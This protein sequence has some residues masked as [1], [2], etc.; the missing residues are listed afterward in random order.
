V[1]ALGATACT[2]GGCTYWKP[3]SALIISPFWFTSSSTVNPPPG[4]GGSV[5]VTCFL[6]PLP[7]VWSCLVD[8]S[9]SPTTSSSNT[10][11]GGSPTTV[12]RIPPTVGPRSGHVMNGA[13]GTKKRRS[14]VSA[15]RAVA[16][17]TSTGAGPRA[18]AGETNSSASLE[19]QREPRGPRVPARAT[20]ASSYVSKF[21]PHTASATPPD[22]GLLGGS[23]PKTECGKR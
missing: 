5:K 19:I 22:T 12:T 16:Q 8:P 6:H 23:S 4:L 20:N 14:A 3:P 10:F 17:P 9:A 1:P 13:N 21:R 2:T 7:R 15:A 18:C 11:S